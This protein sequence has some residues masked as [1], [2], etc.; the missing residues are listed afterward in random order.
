MNI[1]T[2]PTE[3]WLRKATAN[4][5]NS[6]LVTSPFVTGLFAEITA[7]LPQNVE[8]TLI[9]R[10]ELQ[11]FA[12][13][14]SRLESLVNIARQGVKIHSLIN[15]H[16]KIYLVDDSEA[17]VTSANATRM[18]LTRNLECGVV[19]TD[20]EMILQLKELILNGFGKAEN[21]AEWTLAELE[22]LTAPV[23]KIRELLAESSSSTKTEIEQI[24][25]NT[26]NE[27]QKQQLLSSFS[28]WI[29]LTLEGCLLLEDT[30]FNLDALEKRCLPLAQKH[31]PENHHVRAKLRQ[32]LQRLRDLGLVEF[33]GDGSYQRLVI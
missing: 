19:V 13:G 30:K 4:C 10:I 21:L 25:L 5:R 2:T 11:Q 32:Q 24:V 12:R 31:Y 7:E 23:Q 15:L 27:N 22:T 3:N 33:L 8:R 26:R 18:G 29:K 14:S 17:L 1:V 6:F 20:L 16:A 9:T 28:G